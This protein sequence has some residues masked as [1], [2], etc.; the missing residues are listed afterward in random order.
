MAHE[1]WGA[2]VIHAVIF[3]PDTATRVSIQQS[4]GELGWSIE[5]VPLLSHVVEQVGSAWL[6]MLRVDSE[7]ADALAVV[8]A[9]RRRRPDVAICLFISPYDKVSERAF[10]EAGADRIILCPVDADQIVRAAAE[11]L[12]ARGRMRSRG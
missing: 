12:L 4:F 11:A 6:V 2:L 9:L 3:E 1:N 8:H 5:A 7:D 10:L